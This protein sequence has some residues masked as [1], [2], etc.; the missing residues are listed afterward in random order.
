MR[1]HQT[2]QPKLFTS[3]HFQF[4]CHFQTKYKPT[5][6][7]GPNWSLNSLKYGPF[8]QLNLYEYFCFIL[9]MASTIELFTGKNVT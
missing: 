8:W 9:K 1:L 7:F 6:F 4:A 3:I 5:G 2:G